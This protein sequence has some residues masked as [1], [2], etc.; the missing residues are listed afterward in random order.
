[1]SVNAY[2][3]AS[4]LAADPRDTEY[5]AF[6]LVIG[7]LMAADSPAKMVEA[8]YMN[9]RLWNILA[10]DLASPDNRLPQ[11]LR[12]RLISLALWSLKY[13]AKV[14]AGEAEVSPL[15]QVNK[16]IMAG[17]RPPPATAPLVP[18]STRGMPAAQP[19]M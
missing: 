10:A 17:L 2:S 4:Q 9:N 18:E 16:E 5:R 15:I 1:M 6:G 3:R 13:G 14:M 8:V 12:G 7:K 19:A 11:D